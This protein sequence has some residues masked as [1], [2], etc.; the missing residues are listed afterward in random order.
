M[1]D[2]SKGNINVKLYGKWAW[3]LNILYKPICPILIHTEECVKINKII[4]SPDCQYGTDIMCIPEVFLKFFKNVFFSFSTDL[5]NGS[6]QIPLANDRV[7]L[8]YIYSLA[9]SFGLPANLL[10]LW[11]L[12]QLGRS[13]GGGCQLVYI[14]NLLLSDLLQLLTLPL[15]ILYLQETTTGLMGLWPAS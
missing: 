6:C 1:L 13:G 15:W 14:L 8:T 10:S 5:T 11:G 3:Q 2:D 7:G 9:F 12:Y 4:I